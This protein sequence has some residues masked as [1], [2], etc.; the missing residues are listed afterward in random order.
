MEPLTVEFTFRLWVLYYNINQGELK[1]K[2]YIVTAR[3]S[4]HPFTLAH[5]IRMFGVDAD[6]A[7]DAA[8]QVFNLLLGQYKI[9]DVKEGN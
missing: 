7:E 8:E 9:I 5:S 1:M 2:H 6:S 3:L 4:I